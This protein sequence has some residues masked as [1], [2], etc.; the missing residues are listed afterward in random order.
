VTLAGTAVPGRNIRHPLVWI[1]LALSLALNLFFVAG[2]LWTRFHAPPP[3][4]REE[5]FDQMATA[6]ALDPQQ[7]AAFAG[8]SQTMRGQL[9]AMRQAASPLVRAA[10]TELSKPRADEN[11]V[12]ELLDEAE[13]LR[14]NHLNEITE[15]T[16]RFLRTLTPEQ[17]A[18]FV[19]VVHQGP[20]PWALQFPHRRD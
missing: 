16:L 13:Q 7:R 20:P 12:M 5:R 4:T 6:L 11:K 3:L 8:Y 1:A 2:A 17:R 14:R 15:A 10:W 9:E 18:Q 19:K